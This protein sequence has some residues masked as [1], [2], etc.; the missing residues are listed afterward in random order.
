MR[1]VIDTEKMQALRVMKYP[2]QAAF[3]KSAGIDIKTIWHAESGH[4][5][6]NTTVH[7]IAKALKVKPLDISYISGGMKLGDESAIEG[8]NDDRETDFDLSRDE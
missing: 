8:R 3:A 2:T 1:L 7:K 6:S 5:V 4:E